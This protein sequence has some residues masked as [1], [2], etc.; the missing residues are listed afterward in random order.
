M[1]W[2]AFLLDSPRNTKDGWP[3]SNAGQSRQ[4][5]EDAGSVGDLEKVWK[6]CHFMAYH[7]RVQEN[8][9]FSQEQ[10]DACFWEI[11]GPGC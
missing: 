8:S 4:D 11:M 5:V 3:R 7:R 10:T 9:Y 6:E 2:P 1:A